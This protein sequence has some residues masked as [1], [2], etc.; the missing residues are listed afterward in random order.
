MEKIISLSKVLIKDYYEN[1]NLFNK[2][3]KTI[4]KNSKLFVLIIILIFTEIFLSN[5][6]IHFLLVRG[7]EPLFLN[8]FLPILAFIIMFQIV[9]VSAN[10]FY[11]SKDI[12]FILPL[13]I[14]PTELLIAKF[15]TLMTIIYVFELIFGAVPILMYIMLAKISLVFYLLAIIALILFP[16]FFALIIS[17]VMMLI[18]KLTKFIKN[19]DVFQFLVTVILMI[20][21]WVV[22]IIALNSF[23]PEEIN[24]EFTDEVSTNISSKFEKA[25]TFFVVINPTISILNDN[26][27]INTVLNIIKIIILNVVTFAV[28]IFIGKM[29]YLKSLLRNNMAIGNKNGIVDINKIARKNSISRTY[30][31]KEFKMLFRSPAF[32]IQCIL[33]VVILLVTVFICFLLM[34]PN[35]EAMLENEEIKTIVGEL[36]FDSEAVCIILGILQVA[37]T[38]SNIS[39]TAISRDG[40]NAEFMKYIPV[41]LYKQFVY[42]NIPQIVVNIIVS[43]V[44]LGAIFVIFP[45]IGVVNIGLIFIISFLINIINSYLMLLVDLRRPRLNWNSEYTVVKKS[46][47]KIFQYVLMIIMILLFLYLAKVL[48]DTNIEICLISQILVF[49]VLF[50]AIDRLVKKFQNR[51]FNKIN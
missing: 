1:M 16:I 2:K 36:K 28:F 46:D 44:I 21:I 35:I 48:K 7:I 29:T 23:V 41:E 15:S 30:I 19:K 50:V 27:S 20:I 13:P 26:L 9:L 51:L 40:K 38:M 49:S 32:F 4:N 3:T 12:E 22:E 31:E 14:K 47:N 25:N 45:S 10:V 24:S 8:V 37:Y 34:L 42:K 6:I 43:I 33:P 5:K 17:M 11:Y 39:L 18:M